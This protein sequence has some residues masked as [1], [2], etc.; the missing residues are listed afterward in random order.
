MPDLDK[1]AKAYDEAR[2]A[3]RADRKS[4]AKR[5]RFKRAKEALTEARVSERQREEED[6]NHPRGQSMAVVTNEES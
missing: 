1:L 3:Y 5:T 2:K 6:P 4:E